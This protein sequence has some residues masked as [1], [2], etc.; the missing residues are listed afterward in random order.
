MNPKT[1]AMLFKLTEYCTKVNTEGLTHDDSLI[2]PNGGGNCCNWVLGHILSSRNS[3]LSLLGEERILSEEAAKLYQ[4]SSDPIL[5]GK[6]ARSFESLLEDFARSQDRIMGALK[7]IS[8]ED[9]A[10]KIDDETLGEKL[11]TFHFHESYHVGQL[12]LLRRIAGKEGAI[13]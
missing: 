5:D 4:R 8:G 11:A 10:R 9:L 13:K 7:R 6:D 12:G 1:L 2:Q 3:I